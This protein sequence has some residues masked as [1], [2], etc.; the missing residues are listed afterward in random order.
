MK[1]H[2]CL[3][4]ALTSLGFAASRGLAQPRGANIFGVADAN[5]D[6]V[7]P[8]R[9]VSVAVDAADNVYTVDYVYALG[10]E[11][12]LTMR[13]ARG[14]FLWEKSFDQ[15]DPTKWERASWVARSYPKSRCASD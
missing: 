10:A 7:Q 12:I 15:T 1:N 6:W 13:D 14:A 11:M 5:V 8:T 3:C 9:G 2:I 4:I